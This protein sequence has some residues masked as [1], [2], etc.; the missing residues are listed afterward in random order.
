[1]QINDL[2]APISSKTG[3]LRFLGIVLI[4]HGV[5]STLMA[6]FVSIFQRVVLLQPPLSE[7]ISATQQFSLYTG[8][9]LG[10]VVS[11]VSVWLGV[12][13]VRSA[14]V[15]KRYRTSADPNDAAELMNKLGFFVKVVGIATLS[16]I[17]V[18]L[19][20]FLISIPAFIEIAPLWWDTMSRLRRNF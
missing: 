20:I 7:A 6:I 16:W 2:V 3:W 12:L 11:L 18:S 13:L 8:I 19:F 9:L 1:M 15:G 17:A 14:S 4:V 5:I 10:G